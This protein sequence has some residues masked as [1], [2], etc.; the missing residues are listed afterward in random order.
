M[1]AVVGG[2]A[3]SLIHRLFFSPFIGTLKRKT[4]SVATPAVGV[5][6]AFIPFRLAYRTALRRIIPDADM[7]REVEHAVDDAYKH[8]YFF[9]GCGIVATILADIGGKKR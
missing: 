6:L 2:I 9:Y 8:V 7:R 5:I 4:Q 3:F 1:I